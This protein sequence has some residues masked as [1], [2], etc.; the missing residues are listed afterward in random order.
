MIEIDVY[1]EGPGFFW[2]LALEE[3]GSD[4][5]HNRE[6]VEQLFAQITGWA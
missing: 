6:I 4:V 5:H 1:R 2:R 3:T